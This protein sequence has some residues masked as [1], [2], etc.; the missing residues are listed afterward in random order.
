MTDAIEQARE[1]GEREGPLA[2]DGF[3]Q[4]ARYANV[5]L[6]ELRRL[7]GYEDATGA[8]T[9]TEP[10]DPHLLDECVSAFIEA[11]TDGF[12][13]Q[14]IREE[15]ARVEAERVHYLTRDRSVEPW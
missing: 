5:V 3:S 7:A 14:A 13:S 12:P 8:G 15:E 2:F 6:P 10:G 9:Y 1:L 4:S 11:A